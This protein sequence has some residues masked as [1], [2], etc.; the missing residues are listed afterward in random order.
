MGNIDTIPSSSI[1]VV[2]FAA[3][4]VVETMWY[5]S[6][7]TSIE[8]FNPTRYQWDLGYFQKK[9]IDEFEL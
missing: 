3:F 1:I 4:V 8:L 7:T 9:N 2:F 5:C 6:T